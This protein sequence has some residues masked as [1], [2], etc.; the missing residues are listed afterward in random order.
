M[1]RT[2]LL[3]KTKLRAKKPMARHK[4]K[5][6]PGLKALMESGKVNKASTLSG[7]A[8]ER[9]SALKYADAMFSK[10]TRMKAAGSD[11]F[12][13]CFICGTRL[14]WKDAVAMHCEPRVCMPTRYSEVNV[15]AG[16]SGCNSKPL[17]D[18]ESFRQAL[19]N[20]F[21]AMTADRNTIKSKRMERYTNSDLNFIGDTYAKR[22][23]WIT[24]HHNP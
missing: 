1:K 21:G 4:P 19:D 9:T 5:P 3:R 22:I 10:W 7:K 17:G 2:A 15:Q 16:C 24:E 13:R 11:G 12:L 20:E 8:G 6:K 18:R 23:Q 14:H